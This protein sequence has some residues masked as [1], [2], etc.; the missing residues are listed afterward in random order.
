MELLIRP[1]NRKVNI[2][3]GSNLLDTLIDN[4]I[5]ISYSC[6][7]GRCSTCKCTVITGDVRGSNAADGRVSVGSQVLACLTILNSDCIIEI[8]EPDEV[9]IHPARV[10]KG[11]VTC[12][13]YLTHDVIKLRLKTNKS[14][15]F[16]PGQYAQLE[17]SADA[18]RPYSM[19]GIC[20][21]SELEFHI[22]VV[23]NGRVTPRLTRELLVGDSVKISGPLGGSYLRVKHNDPMLCVGGGSGL[24]P[25]LSIVRGA[26]EA[27]MKNPIYLYFGVRSEV[28]VYGLDILEGLK[29]AYSNFQYKV[30]LSASG[31]SS[32]RFENG[33]VTEVI[34]RDMTDLK[35]WRV[36]LAGPPPMVDAATHLVVRS[37]VEAAHI[38]ADAFYPAGI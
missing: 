38:Y 37:G 6:R 12:F 28:D 24:A 18:V 13:E 29:N 23:P 2:S 22:R 26:L 9:V 5:P 25:M 34:K 7:S 15:E 11:V 17:F 36:Y 1:L 20:G 4:K 8:P 31:D 27:G 33:F 19:A 14:L 10:I 30:V 35:G 16:S 21:D 32:S 3:V